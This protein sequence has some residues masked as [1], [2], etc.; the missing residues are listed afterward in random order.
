M[1]APSVKSE[2]NHSRSAGVCLCRH[3]DLGNKRNQSTPSNGRQPNPYQGFPHRL[4]ATRIVSNSASSHAPCSVLTFQH[5]HQQRLTCTSA[6]LSTLES[7]Q[8]SACNLVCTTTKS[9]QP[10]RSLRSSFADGKHLVIDRNTVPLVVWPR[11][12]VNVVLPTAWLSSPPVGVRKCPVSCLPY[13]VA[14]V[15]QKNL[16]SDLRLTWKKRS[17]GSWCIVK[18]GKQLL[19]LLDNQS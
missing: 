16:M 15:T 8:V 12:Q 18:I 14:C 19:N 5:V 13:P 9:I 3:L 10:F 1:P 2:T 4:L 7:N 6:K 17:N 11:V